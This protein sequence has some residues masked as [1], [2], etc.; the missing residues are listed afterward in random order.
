M[1]FQCPL[2]DCRHES[3]RKCGKAPHVPLRCEEVVQK[4]REDE[5]RVRVEEAMAAAKIRKCY[6]CK[7]A[8]VK[9]D[10]C[11][12][13][14]C[15]CGAKMCYQCRTPL[16]GPNPYQHFCQTP[17][18]SHENCG[19]CALHSNA[20]ED[21]RRAMR[22]AGLKAADLYRTELQEE[23]LEADQED[24]APLVDVRIDVEGILGAPP[25]AA[26]ARPRRRR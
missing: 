20:E 1:I 10:G 8:F 15:R 4:K 2:E 9:S 7:T 5:G 14:T 6:K 26:H 22:D 16:K 19:K 18:C 24:E 23:Q 13:M 25:S 11:N 21:D 17:H 3:C 12:K